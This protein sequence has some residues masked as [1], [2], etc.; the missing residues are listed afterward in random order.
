M[1]NWQCAMSNQKC[2]MKNEKNLIDQPKVPKDRADTLADTLSDSI[3]TLLKSNQQITQGEIAH[4]KQLFEN[5]EQFKRQLS[6]NTGQFE[7]KSAGV[8]QTQE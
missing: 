7:R 6:E 5:I 8:M 3:I 4:E 1:R 2:A